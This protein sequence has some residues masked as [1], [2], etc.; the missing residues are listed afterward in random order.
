MH[1]NMIS[2]ANKLNPSVCNVP[3]RTCA[4]RFPILNN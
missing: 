3:V 2:C 4:F 1:Y